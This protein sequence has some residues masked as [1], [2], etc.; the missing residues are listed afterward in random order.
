[1]ALRYLASGESYTS[2][3]MQFRVGL[4][5]ISEIVPEV[6]DSVYLKMS[7]SEEIYYLKLILLKLL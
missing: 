7:N 4:S 3:H 1:M 6:L 2:M 5:T